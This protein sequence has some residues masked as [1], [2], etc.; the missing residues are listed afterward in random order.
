[1]QHLYLFYLFISAIVGVVSLGIVTVD[2]LRSGIKLLRSYVYFHAAFTALVISELLSNYVSLNLEGV[3]H[4]ILGFLDYLNV[5]VAQY[6]LL[7]TFSIFIHAFFNIPQSRIR[8]HFFFC[9][10]LLL[11]IIEHISRFLFHN[12][13]TDLIGFEIDNLALMLVIFYGFVVG[14]SEYNK[15]EP[16]KV[17]LAKRLLI[18]LGILIPIIIFDLSLYDSAPA[19]YPILYC[20]FSISFTNHLIKYAL[21]HSRNETDSSLVEIKTVNLPERTTESLL[22]EELCR[23]YHITPREQEILPLLIQGSRNNQIAETLFVSLSTIKTHLRNIY[24]KF[25]VNN[26]YELVAL[27]KHGDET[28][29]PK[30]DDN[31]QK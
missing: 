15:C 18:I 27:L 9:S 24:A 22:S 20:V 26:R 4:V 17:H 8:N 30:C 11:C 2:Y 6:A 12:E 5:F 19:L 21:D 16:D 3:H 10:A 23:Q 7:A 13:F 1:M 28:L 29:I 31:E 14:I 25:N